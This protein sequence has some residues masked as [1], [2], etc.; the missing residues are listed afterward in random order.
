MGMGSWCFVASKYTTGVT[1]GARRPSPAGA[2]GYRRRARRCAGRCH[3]GG[4]Q[5][6]QLIDGPIVLHGRTGSFCRGMDFGALAQA[7]ASFAPAPQ[8]GTASEATLRAGVASFGRCLRAIRASHRPVIALVDCVVLGGGVGI[9]A[10][11]DLVIASRRSSLG[12]PKRLF[13][14]IPAVVLTA[15]LSRLSPQKAHL[16][17]LPGHSRS[18]EEA[19]AQ[20]L[21]DVLC[22]D[23]KLDATL[24]RS[25]RDPLPKMNIC[26]AYPWPRAGARSRW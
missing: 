13:V 6:R 22:A 9:A 11:C 16:L 21:V 19:Q 8:I 18:V 7:A 26:A 14:L 4:G 10:A 5:G 1:D 24:R 15:P 25:L 2:R 3:G 17:A 12:L 20:G 23:D